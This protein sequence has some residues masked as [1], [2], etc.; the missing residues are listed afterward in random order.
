MISKIILVDEVDGISKED[1]GGLPEL[2]GFIEYAN[3]PIIITA[4]DIWDKNFS[5]LRKESELVQLKEIDYKTIKDVLIAILKKENKFID[6]NILT[7]I[8]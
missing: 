1:W 5:A 7:G 6:N 4:N 3:W 2:V 8:S